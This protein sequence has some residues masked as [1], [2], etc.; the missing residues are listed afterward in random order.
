M[1]IDFKLIAKVAVESLVFVVI[2]LIVFGSFVY[3]AF[4][5]LGATSG[6]TLTLAG[7][8]KGL[9]HPAAYFDGF[10]PQ[11]EKVPWWKRLWQ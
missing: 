4:G 7:V 9:L 5:V 10:E 3:V 2:G 11:P 1:G 8:A 6:V